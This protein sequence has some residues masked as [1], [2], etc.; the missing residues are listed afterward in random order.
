MLL[1]GI[2]R[3]DFSSSFRHADVASNGDVVSGISSG[4]EFS[5]VVAVLEGTLLKW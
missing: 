2:L 1:S 4:S 3:A 5:L